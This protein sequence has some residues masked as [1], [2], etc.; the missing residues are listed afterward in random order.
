MLPCGIFWTL[1]KTSALLNSRHVPYDMLCWGWKCLPSDSR[2]IWGAFYPIPLICELSKYKSISFIFYTSAMHLPS[3]RAHSFGACCGTMDRLPVGASGK[4][5]TYQRRRHEGCG[6]NPWVRKIP[7]R[8]AWQPTPVYSCLENP[9]G[10]G[11]WRAAVHRVTQS[12]TRQKRLGTRVHVWNNGESTKFHCDHWRAFVLLLLSW[13]RN[14]LTL[15]LGILTI[16]MK[17]IILHHKVSV[18]IKITN[19]LQ[20]SWHGPWYLGGPQ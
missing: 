10:R 2:G 16:E 6:L 7:W 12:R 1:G 17:I 13:K 8:R 11:A 9:M 4:E 15:T 3:D 18:R 20:R 5:P 14:L 19:T